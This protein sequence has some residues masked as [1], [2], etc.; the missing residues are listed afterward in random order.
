[1]TG[2]RFLALL[3]AM[4]AGLAVVTWWPADRSAFTPHRLLEIDP[5]DV[6]AIEIARRPAG[7]DEPAWLEL[8]RDG[9][10]WVIPSA[11][12][13][14][15]DPA[16]VEQLIERVAGMQVRAP[17]ATTAAS[18][19]A[20]S[21]GER[22]YGRRV[23]VRTGETAHELII[24]AA[25]SNSV[26]VR[27]AGS[28]EVHVAEGLSEFSVA[29]TPSSYWAREYV[30]APADEISSFFLRNAH[31]A[32]RAERDGEGWRIADA[33]EGRQADGEAID[34]LLESLVGL[35]LAEPVGT[36]VREAHG[37]DDGARV[38]WT[39]AADD[40]SLAGGYG[41]GAVD[42]SNA[43]VKADGDPFVVKVSEADVAPIRNARVDDLLR[44]AA[45]ADADD[46]PLDAPTGSE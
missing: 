42:G 36:E 28:D 7:D 16:R 25:L 6:T 35:R 26:N 34:E 44:E 37:L 40:Q 27:L 3:L 12:G 39:I 15:A 4:Q 8:R 20:L 38:S 31:G 18:H 32:F 2:A 1:M 24:G 21:V 23:V 14:P 45:D 5:A 46:D 9:S 43:F 33:P 19:N 11:N 22:D 29:D 17:I 10:G 30:N 13:Y 41:V